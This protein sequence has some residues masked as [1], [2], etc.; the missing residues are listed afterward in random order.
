MT[1]QERG[2]NH[3]SMPPRP[4]IFGKAKIATLSRACLS[5]FAEDT[6]FRVVGRGSHDQ[7]A[8]LAN[9]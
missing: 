4:R 1:E 5:M 8:S 7:P 6:S 2:E 9:N 3:I